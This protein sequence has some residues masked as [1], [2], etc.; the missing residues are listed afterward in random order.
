MATRKSQ[1]IIIWVIAIVM[2][3]GT[4]GAYFI[5]MITD[6]AAEQQADEKKAIAAY[7]EQLKEQWKT[8]QPLAGYKANSFDK[9][10]VTELKIETLKQGDGT[11]AAATST[12][13][14][15]YFGWNSEGLIF[16]TT[17]K[18]GT[19]EP[20]EFNLGQVIEGWREGLTGVKAGST[21]KLTI[22]AAKAYGDTAIQP[23]T[24]TGPLVFVVELVEVK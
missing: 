24:P 20:I 22:P 23:G 18:T 2:T 3:I 1:R 9:A 6:P 8:N 4:L 17:N 7:E 12:V 5:A 21:V 13:K 10:S 14:A 11:A 15:N 19:P 16:D